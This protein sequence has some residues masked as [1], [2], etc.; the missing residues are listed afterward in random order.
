[1]NETKVVAI[2]GAAGAIAGTI[3]TTFGN[4]GWKLALLDL[5]ANVTKLEERFPASLSLGVDLTRAGDAIAAVSAIEAEYGRLD[6][7]L[8]IAGGFAMQSA[9]EATPEDLERQLAINLST[10][11]NTTT[12]VLP[13]M[14]A[15]GSGFVLGVSAAAAVHGGSR[16]PAY[17]AAKAAVVGFL[18]SVRAEVEAQGVGVSILY[19]MGAVDTPGNRASMP[20]TDPDTWIARDEIAETVLHLATRSPRGRVREV[21]VHAS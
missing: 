3:A 9:A 4:A 18:R 14:L 21:Q 5:E 20:N 1:M 15:R 6:A 16:M 12:A 2:S 8:N 17:G 11:F 7:L 13:G 10:L 19:P